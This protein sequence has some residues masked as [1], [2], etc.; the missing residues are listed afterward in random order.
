MSKA[1]KENK[2]TVVQIG[3]AYFLVCCGQFVRKLNPDELV[4]YEENLPPPQTD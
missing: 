4:R 2:E 3:E 1:A